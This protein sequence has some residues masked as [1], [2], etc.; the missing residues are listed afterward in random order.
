[1]PTVVII[2]AD[3]DVLEKLVI[4]LA[5]LYDKGLNCVDFDG[6]D[7]PDPD[8]DELVRELLIRRPESKAFQ[9][10][11]TSPSEY[12]PEEDP[13]FEG[14]FVTHHPPMTSISKAD[15]KDKLKLY[16]DWIERCCKTLGYEYPPLPGRFSHTYK[17]DG[18]ALRVY[19][20]KGK[21]VRAGLRPRGGIKGIEVTANVAHVQGIPKKLPKSFTLAV[22]GELECFLED[23]E[24]VQ[25]A[26]LEAGEELRANPRNHTYGSINQHKDPSKTK[27]GRISFTGHNIVGFD[28]SDKYYTTEEGRAEFARD[29]LGIPFVEVMPHKFES[30]AGLEE[31]VQLLDYEV[32][33]VV[34]KVSNLEDQEQLGHSGD[35]PT[36]DPR[37]A[38]A[39]K[40]AEEEKHATVESI[41][42]SATRTGRV[43]P[44][45][46]FVEAIRLAG[47]MVKRA[48]LS[49]YGWIKRM[50]IGVGTIVNVI[51]AGKIIPKVI[52]VVSGKVDNVEHPTHCPS[53]ASKLHIVEGHDHNEELMCANETCPAKMVGSFLF[54]LTNIGA[55][56]LGE[57]KMELIVGSGKVKTFADLYKLTVEDLIA[58]DFTER[59][60]LLAL[61]TIHLVKPIKDNGKLLA[62]IEQ[63]R[64]K[65]KLIPAWQVFAALGIP[66][67]G[68]TAGKALIDHYGSFT[69]IM[70]AEPESL[71]TV[72]GIGD[73]SANAIHE[74]FQRRSDEV[75]LILDQIELELPKKGGKLDGA[76]FV[77]SGSFELGKSHWEKVIQDN[78]GK[79]G[80][81]VGS[82]TQFLV[83]GPGA[84]SKLQ[85]AQEL[86]IVV[87]DVEGLEK[88]L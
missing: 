58:C 69:A 68:K 79:V 21:L 9:K 67:A 84:G 19:Y 31:D 34:I 82:K 29:V 23:F 1:M 28:E 14:S 74:Y 47:T 13:E 37:G 30:L 7:V 15:G 77:L 54:F 59:E 72:D 75:L 27:E 33:G 57:S 41:V 32:D 80:S 43:T 66:G 86:G 38:I 36:G 65:K 48:T 26:K 4:H 61:S 71:V 3:T 10:G 8:Y 70:N 88:M 51:K 24:K 18:V 50:G 81:S 85:K 83:A 76:T 87:L 25:A 49:N 60:A 45:S 12:N 2:P 62:K 42:W 52:G 55:K 39:W 78:G 20:E 56:G 73:I 46:V 11:N 35:T 44:V 22:T 63:A 5:T 64:T 40:F 17:R 6:N 53:C 16:N